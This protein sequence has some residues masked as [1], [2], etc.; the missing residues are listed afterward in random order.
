MKTAGIIIIIVGLIMTAYTGFTYVT[1]EKV[2]DLGELEITKDNEHSVHW[3]PYVGIGMIVIG[4]VVLILD[5]K[6]SRT[7]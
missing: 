1:K 3:Q 5:R 7:T 6:K 4:G 2:V